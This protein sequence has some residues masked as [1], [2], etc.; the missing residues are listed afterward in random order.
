[1]THM[2]TGTAVAWDN[3]AKQRLRKSRFKVNKK[4]GRPVQSTGITAS[5]NKNNNNNNVWLSG[6]YHL[7]VYCMENCQ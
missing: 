4:Y 7:Y 6:N 3:R 5:N 2:Q 1:M